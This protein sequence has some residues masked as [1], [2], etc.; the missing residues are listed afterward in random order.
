MN[1]LELH[2]H[3]L[4]NLLFLIPVQELADRCLWLYL[5]LSKAK[6]YAAKI[7]LIFRQKFKTLFMDGIFEQKQFFVSFGAFLTKLGVG[8]RLRK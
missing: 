4:R 7:F 8:G 6:F 5:N 3:Q 1:L 2:H